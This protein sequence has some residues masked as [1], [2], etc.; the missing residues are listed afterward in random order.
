VKS[1]LA[2]A[3]ATLLGASC[4]APSDEHAA[5]DAGDRADS[6]AVV[7]WP[8]Q[9]GVSSFVTQSA[10]RSDEPFPCG[11]GVNAQHILQGE[12]GDN[13]DYEHS[14][15]IVT[16]NRDSEAVPLT[17]EGRG[18]DIVA[19]ADGVVVAAS[20]QE[21][22]CERSLGAGNY[23]IV[24]H[25]H[26]R[27]DGRPILSAYM[28]LNSHEAAERSQECGL[29]PNPIVDGAFSSPEVGATVRAGQKIGELGNT[30]NSTGAHL[31]FQ[32]AT[33]CL[34]APASEVACTAISIL[35]IA[36]QGFS[37]IRVAHD[38]SC[39]E[40]LATGGPLAASFTS[41]YLVDGSYVTSAAFAN[42]IHLAAR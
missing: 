22:E 26:L 33:D 25:P 19:V 1:V 37:N 40:A 28:H 34:L 29:N 23:V 42:E 38:A 6:S 16:R 11:S 27:A 24:E 18:T 8:I 9:G 30:G 10:A 31:H 15:D 12:H 36:P 20:A 39:P 2:I 41:R 4:H 7:Q 14:L 17:Y 13:H 5:A 35:D 3:L 21:S 32:F